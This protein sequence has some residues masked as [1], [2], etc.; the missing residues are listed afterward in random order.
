MSPTSLNVRTEILTVALY[1]L[2]LSP[3][4][5]LSPPPLLLILFH[6]ACPCLRAFAP[7][8]PSAWNALPADVHKASFFA[9][10]WQWGCPG[11]L[12]PFLHSRPLLACA[13][14]SLAFLHW[15]VNPMWVILF[16]VFFIAQSPE[17]WTMLGTQEVL[18]K[19][20]VTEWKKQKVFELYADQG[21][22]KGAWKNVPA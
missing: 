12:F 10:M 18:N 11:H 22:L 9:Q 13:I 15:N 20:L 17:P 21:F 4:Y 8:A 3:L 16:S 14:F 6:H 5:H 2:I 19:Y 1:D 7:A